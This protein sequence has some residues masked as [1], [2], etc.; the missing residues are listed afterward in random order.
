MNWLRQWWLCR[1]KRCSYYTHYLAYEE[2]GEPNLS[3]DA[4]HSAEAK[5]LQVQEWA[6]KWDEE[7]KCTSTPCR[8]RN[9][10]ESA[11]AFWEKRVRA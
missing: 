3:H 9:P 5:C 1:T 2:A 11:T 8:H 6:E 7:H 10:F 4:Y